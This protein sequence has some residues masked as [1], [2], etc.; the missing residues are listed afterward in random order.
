MLN[1]PGWS[2]RDHADWYTLT[3]PAND[4]RMTIF[5]AIPN[6]FVHQSVYIVQR[7]KIIISLY[8][9]TSRYKIIHRD[10]ELLTIT[11]TLL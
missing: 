7:F 9:F 5:V 3:D 8:L 2:R 11:V 6:L 10:L 1:G 4:D